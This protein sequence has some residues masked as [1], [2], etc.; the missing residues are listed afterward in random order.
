MKLTHTN[1]FDRRSGETQCRI[2]KS[3]I[4][5]CKSEKG[6]AV[7]GM[8][9]LGGMGGLEDSAYSYLRK[10]MPILYFTPGGSLP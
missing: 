2:A 3:G 9:G 6:C 7:V 1:R 10:I 4:R 5:H 8:G